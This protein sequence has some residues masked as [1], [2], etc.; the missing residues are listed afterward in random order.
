[1]WE[2]YIRSEKVALDKYHHLFPARHNPNLPFI[3]FQQVILRDR[4]STFTEEE[5]ASAKQF[6]SAQLEEVR[7]Q[8]EC[9]W[10]LLK[11]NKA[12]SEVNLER[13][14]IKQ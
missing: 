13:R 3:T 9:P 11:V 10:K 12:Q 4:A 5:L 8:D 2:S 7:V 6:I 1:M 14:Y